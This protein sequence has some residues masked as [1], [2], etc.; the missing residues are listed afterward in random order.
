MIVILFG[1]LNTPAVQQ[2]AK[3]LIVEELKAKLGTELGIKKLSFYPFNTLAIDSLYLYDQSNEKVLMADKVSAGIDLFA[4]AKG[5]IVITSAW[6]TD[7]E[8]H[9]SKDSTNAPL[10][11]QYIIDAFKSKDDKPKAKLDI[12]LNAVNIS[13]GR[14]SY[15]VKDRPWKASVF[16]ANHVD[17]S[18]LNAK[19]TVKSILEDSLNVQVKKI[20]L[21]EKSGLEISDLVFK[22]VSQGK[23][24]SLRGF[25]LDMP[26]SSLVFDKFELDLTPTGDSAKVQDYAVVDC[27]IAPSYIAPKDIAALVPALK[28]FKD[29]LN[30]RANIHASSGNLDLSELSIDFGEKL[31]LTANAEIRDAKDKDKMYLLGSV[32]ELTVSIND[33]EDIVNN[34]ST[35]K[36][37]LPHQLKRLGTVSFEGDISGYMKQLTAFGSLDTDLGIVK[38][39][40]L[41]GLN[42]RSGI[43]SFVQ[44]K[45]Y[46]TDFE[47][48]NLLDNKDL[49]KISLNLAVEM[50]KPTHGKLKG[51]AE[52]DIHNFDFKG[53][54]YKEIT[55]D[56]SYDGLRLEGQLD[57]DDENGLLSVN[58]LFDL[59]DKENPDLNFKA[60]VKNVQLDN[61]HIAENM[62]HSYISFV[63]DADFTGR[64]IDNAEGYVRIDSI[65]FIREDKFFQMDSLVLNITGFED[66][67]QLTLN[68]NLIKGQING[69]YSILSMVGSVKQTLGHYLPALIKTSENK[70]YE[71]QINRMNF[72]FQVNNTESLSTILK[73]PVTILSPS[74]II[75]SYDNMSNNFNLEIFAPSVKAAG[76]NIKSG[77]VSI[78]N[79]CDTIDA[80]INVLVIGKK[81]AINDIAINSRI[82]NNLI[83]TDISLMNTGAQRARGNFSI[84]TLL[85]KDGT[86][87]FRVD[88]DM[89]PSDLLLNNADWR[90]DKSH[91][92]IQDGLI[93]VDNFR[94]Y[95]DDGSQ[96]IKINGKYTQKDSNDILKA[97]LK[98]INLEYIFQT[99]AIDALQFGGA[100]TGSLFVSSIEKKPY[101]N[102]RLNVTDFKF[103]GAELG[104]LNLFSEL[105]DETSQVVLDGLIVSHEN[106]RTKVDGTLDPVKQQLSINFDADS[107]N[108]GFLNKYAETI[109]DNITGRGTGK[110]HLHGN[111]SK[112]TVEGKAFIEDGSF[113]IRF[114]NTRYNFTDTVYLKNDLI[115]FNDITMA[116]E[117]NN[118]AQVSGKVA[119]DLFSNFMYLIELNA[120][121][122]LVYNATPSVNPLFYGKV[123]GSGNGTIG[124]D[125]SGVDINVRMR[126]EANT[127][128]RMNFM[129]DVVNEYSFITYKDKSNPDT[130]AVSNTLPAYLRN[131]SGMDINMH[132]YVDA[133]PDATLELLMD[134]AGGDILKGTG[135]GAM[136]F[137]WN[138]KSS[139]KLFGTYNINRG[140]YNFTFQRLMERRF[141]IVD[142]SNVQFRG[143]PFEATLDVEAIYKVNASLNDLD[144][145]LADRVGQTTIPVNCVLNLTG[146][147]K[148]PNVGLDISLPSTDSEVE[149]QVKSILNTQDEINKQVA[150]LL[151]LSK[152]KAPSYANPGSQTSDFAALASSTLSNQL[153][154]IVSKIDD[155]WQLGTNIRYS[156]TELTNTEAEL[157]LSSQLLNDRLLIN[158]NFGYRNDINL[159]NEAMI[160]D[161]DIEYL[162]NNAGTWRIKAYNH[163]NEK[164][165]YLGHA[166]QTQGVGIIYKKDF[167]ELRDLFH[168]TRPRVISRDSIA[169]LLPDSIQKGS[170]L[171]PFIRMKK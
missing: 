135:S 112:V 141:N 17:V 161:I 41:F 8:V 95:N 25:E 67:R 94:V 139:P 82:S 127:L 63:M 91:I 153:T 66:S 165:Y 10:N 68:S 4:L 33:I 32:D 6:L 86:D 38:T 65:D 125:E 81:D 15:N 148:H 87:P 164:Y 55:L 114:L 108:I 100:A 140:S 13:N 169:P 150:Y 170:T 62:K 121:N 54:T 14:F 134:P 35:K 142:G 115:Y 137:E 12:K 48:G 49:N 167:D 111:F 128:V 3:D 46:T 44:G 160:T 92:A 74:K 101:L 88:I 16:D 156:D 59:T 5:K 93:D 64:H 34:F 36:V 85:T 154:K 103:N 84:A 130:T 1:L 24:Y 78:K 53:Y 163:Y 60:K 116:D 79:P 70:K 18:D 73:L 51:K 113:G 47:L 30:L 168:R 39:D 89:L 28:N 42:P 118:T 69:I 72:D 52:G 107:I 20:S 124:G 102:T 11:I 149:R 99:L 158:G 159:K 117:Y 126:T 75:G 40:V 96:E 119:H 152:F 23:K 56:A 143:D 98:N 146:P 157:L 144:K 83:N 26:S 80:K 122:F 50:E 129:E 57:V 136:Q 37:N 162:L 131:D 109:F 132:F 2:Y 147:L 77:Y 138:M 105:D 120:N 151:I 43:S 171:S 71:E 145:D 31:H 166:T 106:K 90:M 97:E 123:F 155:R 9:L 7:M 45:V 61:L 22:L 58:G 19:L 76:M 104:N 29:V 110:V 21:K 27:R 133:T